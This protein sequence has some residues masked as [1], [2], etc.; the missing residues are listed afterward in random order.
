MIELNRMIELE[1]MAEEDDIVFPLYY[2]EWLY[3]Q[4]AKKM[5]YKEVVKLIQYYQN[6]WYIINGTKNIKKLVIKFLSEEHEIEERVEDVYRIL[7]YKNNLLNQH[8]KDQ[9]EMVKRMKKI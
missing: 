9:K 6:H 2:G 7:E 4:R 5:P 8:L 1:K 3:I